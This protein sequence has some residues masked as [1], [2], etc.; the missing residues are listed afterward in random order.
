[1]V[2]HS[3]PG[4]PGKETRVKESVGEKKSLG[5][6]SLSAWV[7]LNES[8]PKDSLDR[9]VISHSQGWGPNSNQRKFKYQAP[10]S[11]GAWEGVC[12]VPRAGTQLGSCAHSSL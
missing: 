5:E 7:C 1:M 12:Q 2:L 6:H 11:G 8:S 4:S 9:G 3:L 10:E